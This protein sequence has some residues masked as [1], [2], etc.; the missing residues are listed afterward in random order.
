MP[1]IDGATSTSVRT[2]KSQKSRKMSA[3]SSPPAPSR[4]DDP[5]HHSASNARYGTGRRALSC[6][7]FIRQ[8]KRVEEHISVAPKIR[9]GPDVSTNRHS[10]EVPGRLVLSL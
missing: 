7:R 5:R 6:S 8:P 9:D 1:G 10:K 2:G 4:H 3:F